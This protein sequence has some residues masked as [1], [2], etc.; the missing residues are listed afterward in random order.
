MD[1]FLYGVMAAC[2]V[3]IAWTTWSSVCCNK[4]FN[5]R[6]EMLDT[7][8]AFGAASDLLPFYEA[9]SFEQH[10]RDLMLFR[11]PM[12]RYDQRLRDAVGAYRAKLTA[13]EE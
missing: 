12:A 10:E 4:T 7:M 9:V 3:N 11:D 6:K 5:A 2:G 13:Q 1:L 8:D